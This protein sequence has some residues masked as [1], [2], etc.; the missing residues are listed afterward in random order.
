M[1]KLEGIEKSYICSVRV[2]WDVLYRVLWNVV[3]GMLMRTRDSIFASGI[4][5]VCCNV[6]K[7]VS[8][9]VYAVSEPPKFV[10]KR[11]FIQLTEW[12]CTI[13]RQQFANIFANCLSCEGRLKSRTIF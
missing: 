12:Y 8:F 13:C 6:F 3:Y 10:N 4:N 1:K 2:L 5:T 11:S 9:C 7:R